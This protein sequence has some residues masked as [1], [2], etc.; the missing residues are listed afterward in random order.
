MAEMIGGLRLSK[1][2][3]GLTPNPLATRTDR[4]PSYSAA[5]D[6]QDEK[7]LGFDD[8]DDDDPDLDDKTDELQ[9]DDFLADDEDNLDDEG[10]VSLGDED[11][12][13]ED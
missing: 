1:W 4:P 5:L 2:L 9:A 13:E 11:F 3:P 8:G 6:S 12:E 10:D 7:D